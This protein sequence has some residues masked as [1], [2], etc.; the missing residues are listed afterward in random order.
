MKKTGAPSLAPFETWAAREAHIG[1]SILPISPP[2]R[3]KPFANLR[4]APLKPKRGLSGPT[5]QIRH[6]IETR[7]KRHHTPYEI[8]PK[9]TNDED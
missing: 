9:S 5:S 2:N 6:P 7:T 3:Q 4:T 8:N 1:K